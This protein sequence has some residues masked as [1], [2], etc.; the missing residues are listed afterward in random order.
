MMQKKQRLEERRREKT[1]AQYAP[2]SNRGSVQKQSQNGKQ[3][4]KGGKKATAFGGK[5]GPLGM[6]GGG[7]QGQPPQTQPFNQGGGPT[8]NVVKNAGAPPPTQ[9]QKRA[10][11]F[12][13]VIYDSFGNAM[14]LS[15]EFSN[16]SQESFG[17]PPQQI[18][19]Q[20]NLNV[21]NNN[22]RRQ[23]NVPPGRPM[24]GAG[25]NPRQQQ[26]HQKPLQYSADLSG[27]YG[28]GGGGGG[29]GGGGGPNFQNNYGFQQKGPYI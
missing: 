4:Q 22:N 7:Q 18:Y 27:P 24:G 6:A 1:Q 11:N 2:E 26:F 16:P 5:K 13:R 15:Q 21:N 8:G 28:K 20:N 23:T 17:R 9:Q 10:Q 14:H 29:V 19:N 12:K 25:P 3:K